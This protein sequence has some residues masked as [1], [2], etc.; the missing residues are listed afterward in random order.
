MYKF[1]PLLSLLLVQRKNDIEL[2][3]FTLH[4]HPR[5]MIRTISD[6]LIGKCLTTVWKI[7]ALKTGNS[8]TPR[9]RD[10]EILI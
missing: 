3:N 2:L 8:F 10:S 1:A 6:A 4:I 7:L 5:Q 9:S